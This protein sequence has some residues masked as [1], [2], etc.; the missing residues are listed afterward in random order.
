MEWPVVF[1]SGEVRQNK[2]KLFHDLGFHGKA[3]RAGDQNASSNPS[4]LQRAPPVRPDFP[5]MTLQFSRRSLSCRAPPIS[6]PND[7]PSNLLGAS[8]LL[9]FL[10]SVYN[11]VSAYQQGER[12]GDIALTREA[13]S[14]GG[15]IGGAEIGAAIGTM[16]FP[17]V[18]TV[19]GG[20]IGGGV[21]AY[22]GGNFGDWVGNQLFDGPFPGYIY[23]ATPA[24]GKDRANPT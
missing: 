20:L 21:G 8:G 19:I 16:I 11:V 5:R 3:L 7:G 1:T 18:G 2:R 10:N 12:Q 24:Y 15:A 4:L 23:Y 9:F 17:G 14:W 13:F 6:T 22:Y